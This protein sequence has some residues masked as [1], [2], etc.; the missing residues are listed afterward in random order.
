MKD[1]TKKT[2]KELLEIT[3]QLIPIL[4]HNFHHMIES[5]RGEVF[6]LKKILN[7]QFS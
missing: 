2:N 6:T 1:L 4:E 7:E 5:S 3:Q